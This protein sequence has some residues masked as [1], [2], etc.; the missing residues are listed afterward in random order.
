MLQGEHGTLR[1]YFLELLVVLGLLIPWIGPAFGLGVMTPIVL[2]TVQNGKIITSD[3]D[4]FGTALSGT[5]VTCPAESYFDYFFWNITNPAEV[6]LL[7]AVFVLDNTFM[8]Q[9]D[10]LFMKHIWFFLQIW[11]ASSDAVH[12][13]FCKEYWKKDVCDRQNDINRA[14]VNW[15]LYEMWCLCLNMTWIDSSLQ[16]WRH[17]ACKRLGPMFFWCELL[18]PLSILFLLGLMSYMPV[19]SSLKILEVNDI[20]PHFY[21]LTFLHK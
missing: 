7:S 15:L 17:H 12:R 8:M 18:P 21:K 2:L 3:Q 1:R 14:T 4:C 11:A 19:N 10:I 13:P 5:A 6:D 9:F 20:E 16:D